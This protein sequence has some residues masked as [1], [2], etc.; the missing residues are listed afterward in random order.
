M[1]DVHW[2]GNFGELVE[3]WPHSSLLSKYQACSDITL[4][5]NNQ[6]AALTGSHYHFIRLYQLNGRDTKKEKLY[7]FYILYNKGVRKIYIKIYRY[8]I[9]CQEIIFELLLSIS[10]FVDVD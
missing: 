1:V 8:F 6:A 7:T 5:N 10:S 3:M 9:S 2:E 4:I